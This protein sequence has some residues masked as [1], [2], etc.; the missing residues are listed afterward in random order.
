MTAGLIVCYIVMI[1]IYYGNGWG[2][3]SLPFMST[4]LLMANGTTYPVTE[5]FSGGVLDES[6]LEYYGIPKLS[7][8]FAYAMFIGNAA[9]CESLGSSL[10]SL[11]L[12]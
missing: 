12:K 7:G 3:R 2:A 4:D 6:L 11:L 1:A 9:V 8:S 10:F 5:V